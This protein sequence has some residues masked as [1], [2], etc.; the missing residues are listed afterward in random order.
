MRWGLRV[1]VH[2]TDDG[3]IEILVR[4]HALRGLG[5]QRHVLIAVR[6]HLEIVR[7]VG[8]WGHDAEALAAQQVGHGSGLLGDLDPLLVLVVIPTFVLHS[9]DYLHCCSPVTLR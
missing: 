6:Q 4:F 5:A 2:R 9:C 8:E 3:Q 7:T 1:E